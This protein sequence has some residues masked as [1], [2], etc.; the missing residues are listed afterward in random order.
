VLGRH[1]QDRA[2]AASHVQDALV[3]PKVQRIEQFG[4]KDELPAERAVKVEPEDGQDEQGR[5]QWRHLA[6]DY[7]D[8]I[9]NS[10]L[11]STATNARFI[12]RGRPF[13]LHPRALVLTGIALGNSLLATL[14][15]QERQPITV[16]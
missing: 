9:F 14:L 3:P 13:T 2:P 5:Q 16:L 4:P 7:P 10:V 12:P 15:F 8:E 6:A 11:T 1:E